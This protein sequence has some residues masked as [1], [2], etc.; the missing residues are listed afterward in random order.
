M[1][2]VELKALVSLGLSAG[3]LLAGLSDGVGFDDVT[4]LIDVARKA[5][6]GLAGAK[7]AFDEYKNMSDAEAADLEAFVVAD[8]DIKDD[9][10]ESVIEQA[11]KVVIELHELVKLFAPKA[12]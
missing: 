12:A 9:A 5:G 11:L 10:V 2:T 3:E 7:L 4:K 1:A 8:F 6:P